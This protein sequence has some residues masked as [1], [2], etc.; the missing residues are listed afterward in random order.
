MQKLSRSK[1]RGSR[2]S[3]VPQ[4]VIRQHDGQPDRSSGSWAA[5][6]ALLTSGQAGCTSGSTLGTRA[7]FWAGGQ[8]FG[9]TGSQAAPRAAG[10]CFRQHLR[11][12]GRLGQLLWQS[13]STSGRWAALWATRQN[14]RQM[15]D[16]TKITPRELGA[17][18]E[19]VRAGHQNSYKLGLMTNLWKTK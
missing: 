7:E 15:A 3:Q 6:Q 10:Q 2:N 13:G 4:M 1:C 11:H 9:Q 14:L 5:L 19:E 18:G 8:H 16:V 17:L 12:M